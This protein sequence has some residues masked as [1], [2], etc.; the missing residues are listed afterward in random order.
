[1]QAVRQYLLTALLFQQYQRALQYRGVAKKQRTQHQSF[2]ILKIVISQQVFFQM[3]RKM[4]ILLQ[5]GIEKQPAKGFILLK[6]CMAVGIVTKPVGQPQ[7]GRVGIPPTSPFF[8][9]LAR[10]HPAII[11]RVLSK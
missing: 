8:P 6:S 9:G 1:M 3:D 10:I 5:K 4:T 11:C 7:R 2:Q